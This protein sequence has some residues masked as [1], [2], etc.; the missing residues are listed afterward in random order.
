MIVG[1]DNY[2]EI[3]AGIYAS[4]DK[5]T[6]VLD[7]FALTTLDRTADDELIANEIIKGLGAE[8][9]RGYQNIVEHILFNCG[10]HWGFK[11]KSIPINVEQLRTI[12]SR[13]NTIVHGSDIRLLN[14]PQT[15]FKV[16][17]DDM[18][19]DLAD[20]S[21]EN[22]FKEQA[23]FFYRWEA[24]VD[25]YWG[26]YRL[27]R[28][29]QNNGQ[30]EFE[31][32]YKKIA[33]ENDWCGDASSEY[34]VW[35]DKQGRYSEALQY[36]IYATRPI[37]DTVNREYAIGALSDGVRKGETCPYWKY[38]DEK[39]FIKYLIYYLE[40]D[41]TRD[42]SDIEKI[43]SV[44]ASSENSQIA[45]N[46][47]KQLCSL[48]STGVFAIEDG[49]NG[50]IDIL[51]FVRLKLAKDIVL[52]DVEYDDYI[53]CMLSRFH[54]VFNGQLDEKIAQ[55]LENTLLA[56]ECDEELCYEGVGMTAKIAL[57]WLYYNG[58]YEIED[59]GFIEAPS[60]LNRRKAAEL[61]RYEFIL[62]LDINPKLVDLIGE[63]DFDKL[64][65]QAYSIYPNK[66]MVVR[67]WVER[68]A[69]NCEVDKLV[70][71]ISC[72]DEKMASYIA[73]DL[74]NEW[75][76]FFEY[77]ESEYSAEDIEKILIAISE[78]GVHR[79]FLLSLYQFGCA[80]IIG[81][82]DEYEVALPTLKNEEK[83]SAFAY[84]HSIELLSA[85]V[86]I[87]P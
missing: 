71:V 85:P 80:K 16:V 56:V 60:L 1:K 3:I 61:L 5:K 2:N 12:F 70:Y 82:F 22:G 25:Y 73:L 27:G 87:E 79:T 17:T 39:T 34:G 45:E 8:T 30:E 11:Y 23:E 18:L 31:E 13:L 9:L 68:C 20:Q 46:A 4:E 26:N 35:L 63:E 74:L 19:D 6:I 50:L 44:R 58:E 55:V 47:K 52:Q 59:E 57:F 51:H 54:N 84:K 15:D 49:E 29:L 24:V 77:E 21:D 65:E 78:K 38:F 10:E 53:D 14:I 28:F 75:E 64:L 37:V 83:A 36:L 66:D 86:E 76:Y 67:S 7:V 40:F 32:C 48:E 81:S 43:L 62:V 72:S 33:G 69:D 42:K 41:L